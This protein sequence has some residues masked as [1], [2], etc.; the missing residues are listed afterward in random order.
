VT[1]LYV[2]VSSPKRATLDG[3]GTGDWLAGDLTA[4]AEPSAGGTFD[5]AWGTV[6]F[7]GRVIA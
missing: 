7:N 3:V 6:D 5:F 1:A 4:G 2:F